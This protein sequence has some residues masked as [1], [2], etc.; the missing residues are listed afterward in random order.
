[1]IVRDVHRGHHGRRVDGQPRPVP[2]EH[3]EVAQSPCQCG[4][5]ISWTAVMP[6]ERPAPPPAAGAPG[7][8]GR[9]ATAGDPSTEPRRSPPGSPARWGLRR[10]RARRPRWPSRPA[11]SI[12]AALAS[13]DVPVGSPDHQRARSTGVELREIGQPRVGPARLVEA[14]QDRRGPRSRAARARAI[15]SS[16]RRRRPPRRRGWR[17]RSRWRVRC[18]W[19]SMNPGRIVAPGRST[20]RSASGGSPVPTRWTCR[21]STRIHSPVAG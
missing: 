1:M 20:T 18:T 9:T 7:S 2:Q 11:A 15:A 10:R 8:R 19:V 17:A 5:D 13:A 12:A 21:P 14:L 16:S 4:I 3:L 6:R